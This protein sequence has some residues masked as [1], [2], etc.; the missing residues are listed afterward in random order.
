MAA[1]D[2]AAEISTLLDQWKK[3]E[4]ERKSPTD[5]LNR[6]EIEELV[7]DSPDFGWKKMQSHEKNYHK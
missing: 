7:W 6:Y 5:T 2:S 1:L 4:E 3:D